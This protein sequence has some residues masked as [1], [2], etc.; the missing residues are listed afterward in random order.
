MG[1][2]TFVCAAIAVS[3]LN[4]DSVILQDVEQSSDSNVTAAGMLVGVALMSM[5]IE[6]VIT[7][8]RFCTKSCVIAIVVSFMYYP[9]Q[10]CR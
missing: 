4:G 7:A 1:F 6:G 2:P 10:Q 8:M 5:S 3:H 9:L